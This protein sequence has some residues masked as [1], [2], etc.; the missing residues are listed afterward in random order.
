MVHSWRATSC[1]ARLCCR[2]LRRRFQVSAHRV[3]GPRNRQPTGA[4]RP[5]QVQAG[6]RH[7][8][9]GPGHC[10]RPAVRADSP[11]VHN[12]VAGA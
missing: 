7:C 4:S 8:D 1:N 3:S 12:R 6:C 11:A 10:A 2:P 9:I 5:F